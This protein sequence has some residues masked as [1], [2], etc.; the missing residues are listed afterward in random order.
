MGCVA[1]LAGI[2]E[3]YWEYRLKPWDVC[4]GVLMVEEAGG[5]VTTMDGNA[6]SVFERSVLATN[7]AV[8]EQVLAKTQPATE[9]LQREGTDLSQWYV[10][11]GY[12]V[13]TGAQLEV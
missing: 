6:Y 9:R 11:K 3:G 10:P 1:P 12:K 4:A 13:H 2:V 5:R 7:D 8:W